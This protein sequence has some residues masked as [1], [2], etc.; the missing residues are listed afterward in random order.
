[1]RGAGK[2]RVLFLLRETP[3]G[4]YRAMGRGPTSEVPVFEPFRESLPLQS[5]YY[6]FIIDRN[7]HFRVK[8]GNVQSHAAMVKDRRAAAAGRFRVN[9]LGRV[10][11]V[12]CQ[13]TDFPLYFGDPSHWS[14]RYVVRSFAKHEAFD[15]A[16]GAVFRFYKAQY[17][18][19]H[20]SPDGSV[21]DDPQVRLHELL[22]EGVV[23][24]YD[25]RRKALYRAYR[26][27]EPP[28]LYPMHLDQ[29]VRAIEDGDPDGGFTYGEPAPRLSDDLEPPDRGKNNFVIDRRGWLVI[30]MTGHHILSGGQDVGGAGHLHLE[31]DGTISRLELNFSGHYRP[32]LTADYCR[33]VYKTIRSHPLADVKDGCQFAGRV[34]KG[35]EAVSTVL[36]FTKADLEGDDPEFDLFIESLLL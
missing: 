5:G 34:F 20:Q 2:S 10:V 11:E 30:G 13:S 19:W 8:R 6:S 3:P 7:G 25:S 32:P 28:A 18:S 31:P 12:V 24:S 15:L 4:V 21:I 33:Y 22:L 36:T 9:R 35:C 1:M 27:A 23:A 16:P 14:A 29:S 26:P 17:E